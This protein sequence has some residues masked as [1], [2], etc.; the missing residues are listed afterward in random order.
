VD[1]VAQIS[2]ETGIAAVNVE[3]DT[4]FHAIDLLPELVNA[5]NQA[6]FEASPY[7]GENP[8]M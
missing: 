7:F 3:A 2:L 5:I 1:S 4:H 6:G 8:G